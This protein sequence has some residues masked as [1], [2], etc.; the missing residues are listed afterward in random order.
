[1]KAIETVNVVFKT[2]LDIGFTDLASKV[3]EQ[4]MEQYIPRAIDLAE[5]LSEQADN[6]GFVWTTG[7]WLIH[8][9][10]KR[11]SG[12]DKAKMERAIERGF[13]V[14]HGLPF[15][16]HTELMDASLFEYGLS[17]SARLD[18][19]FGK[20]TIAAKMTDVPGHTKAIIPYLAKRGI[21][22]LHLG[23]NPASK[24]PS[25]PKVFVWQGNDG[26]EVIVQY[27]GEYGDVLELD[28]IRDALV[29]AHT[30]DNCGPP[31]IEGIKREYEGLSLRFPGATLKASTL[32]AFAE[33]LALLKDRLPVVRE[34]IGDSWIHGTAS[35]PKKLA[36]FRALL[37]LRNKWLQENRFDRESLEYIDFSDNL[38]LVAEHTWGMDEKKFL[39][40]Y[41]NYAK[42][43]FAAARA[44]DVVS[45]DA[46]PRK[47][48][49]FDF[50]RL[51][52]PALAAESDNPAAAAGHRPS[53]R[54]LES[55]WLEQRAYIRQAIDA[56]AP[57]KRMEARET[58]EELEPVR[59]HPEGSETLNIY[60]PHRLGCFQVEFA[61]DGSI[62]AL[63]GA[64]GKRWADG[65][66]RLA[67]FAYE[68]FGA[69][70]Y[71][72][73]FE[74]YVENRDQTHSWSDADFG[75][76]GIEN[77]R[78]APRNRTYAPA[79]SSLTA[80][81]NDRMDTVYAWLK[82]PLE[83]TESYGAPREV[84]IEYRFYKE[85]RKLDVVLQWF[86]KPANRLPEAVWL[87][88]APIVDNPN[89]WKLDKMGESVSP[90]EVVKNGNRNLH[91][92]DTGIH[93]DGADGAIAIETLDAALVA[94]GAKSMLEFDPNFASL[95]GGMHINLLNNVWGTNFPMWYEDNA[96]F[97]FSFTCA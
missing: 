56:L 53:Y 44:A 82:L 94:P 16:T 77:V 63:V 4:Y 88:F 6:P 11:A 25:V 26:A 47:Y 50:F 87:S 72:R 58:L 64:D 65:E 43:D 73:W 66:H 81:N 1:M 46:V 14:W 51:N 62:A 52:E 91:A 24:V 89:L 49:Y 7:S 59:P 85:L 61:G 84:L 37:R 55:S 78:P 90:L 15:T 83:A 20:K 57:D 3:V 2:H 38:L 76:P 42:R 21:R 79:L 48:A 93:Y 12:A 41:R 74:Q 9:Y 68:T 29:F 32:D 71:D 34:E 5:R 13:I 27:A 97:R 30:G 35:D 17:L 75:K 45:G 86:D 22:Y 69:E 67:V 39:G 23:V 28:G 96:K 70:N 18:A 80:V 60:T 10:L 31:S 54:L 92:V 95:D 8:E 40:D 19:R 33:R 36:Q